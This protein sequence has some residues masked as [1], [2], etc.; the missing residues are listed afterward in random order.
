MRLKCQS[1]GRLLGRYNRH[2]VKDDILTTWIVPMNYKEEVHGVPIFVT[3]HLTTGFA[4]LPLRRLKVCRF[5]LWETNLPHGQ[6]L[7]SIFQAVSL[8]CVVGIGVGINHWQWLFIATSYWFF[9]TEC[10]GVS[11]S[12]CPSKAVSHGWPD[13]LFPLVWGLAKKWSR[14][15]GQPVRRV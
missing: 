12:I 10:E 1:Y 2:T 15:R 6:Q 13:L 8:C 4:V 14:W 11:L 9:G 3:R 7:S 5:L